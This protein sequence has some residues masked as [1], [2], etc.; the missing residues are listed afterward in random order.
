MLKI[1]EF[2]AELS[3]HGI[4]ISD[5]A[6]RNWISHKSISYIELPGKIYRKY[7]IPESE[8]MRIMKGNGN[9]KS[10]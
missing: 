6:I 8:V 7:R 1:S 3:K 4:E 5:N 9:T 2:R 10:D